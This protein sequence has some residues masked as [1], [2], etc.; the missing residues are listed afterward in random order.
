MKFPNFLFLS[1]LIFAGNLKA[2]WIKDTMFYPSG[3]IYWISDLDAQISSREGWLL[4]N[5]YYY[6]NGQEMKEERVDT[7]MNYHY[8]EYFW[9][10]NGTLLVDNGKGKYIEVQKD[11]CVYSISNGKYEGPAEKYVR[12]SRYNYL[13]PWKLAASGNYVNGYKNGTWNFIDTSGYKI[14]TAN[15]SKDTLRGKYILYYPESSVMLSAGNFE[16]C[17]KDG[18]WL[19]Y[20][21]NGK[22]SEAINYKNGTRTGTYTGYYPDGKVKLKGQYSQ[23]EKKL[24]IPVEDP[25]NPGTFK[26]YKTMMVVAFKSGVW[27]YYD[28]NG[29]Q[30]KKEKP[31]HEFETPENYD[32]LIYRHKK[33]YDRRR[34]F[35][36]IPDCNYY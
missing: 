32:V 13:R 26:S 23:S 31:K 16:N 19:Y 25:F 12:Y 9:L 36:A 27:I 24:R 10:E 11:S 30:V 6:E 8:L 3:K 15:Y 18:E 20:D 2:Q 35:P 1:C 17:E 34:S 14:V 29:N 28:E 22:I 4:Y 7:T 21:E 5:T 33:F